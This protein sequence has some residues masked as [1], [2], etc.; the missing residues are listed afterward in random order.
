MFWE[1]ETPSLHLKN[2]KLFRAACP[3][4]ALFSKL[5]FAGF[6]LKSLERIGMSVERTVLVFYL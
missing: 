3:E 4:V 6:V 5:V 1:E 2:P